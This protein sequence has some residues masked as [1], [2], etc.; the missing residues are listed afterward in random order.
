[1]SM[2]EKL[3]A[4]PR[5][6]VLGLVLIA[7]IIPAIRPLGLP[8]LVGDMAR[9][10]YRVVEELPEGSVVLF[11]IGYGSGG[12][13]SLGPANVAVFHHFFKRGLKVVIM[14][15]SA[16]GPL[17]YSLVMEK[18]KPEER[19][20]AVYGEDYVLL[21][22]IAG[23]QTAMAAVLGDLH[24][25]VSTDYFGTSIAE[26]PLLREVRGAEDIALVAYLTTAGE[27][28]EGW[29]YQAYSAYGLPLLGGFLSMMTPS[30]KPYYDTGQLLGIIDGLKGA[31]DMEYL[32]GVPGDAIRSS[33]ILSFTQTM[34]LIF[35][36]IGNVSY[37]GAKMA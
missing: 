14:A 26:I 16:E 3:G 29:V 18:V 32:V 34:V 10:W 12:Y 5:E 36:I 35:I 2:L 21:G 19:Y 7:M 33:D 6:V 17:M 30:L 9:D 15:T 20:G 22:Y 11:D 27:T 8:I 37:F 25:A 4:L 13:P 23:V 31:A 28:A 1:M 24:A